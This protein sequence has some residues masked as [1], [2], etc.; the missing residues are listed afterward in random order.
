VLQSHR[1]GSA[2]D[3]VRGVIDALGSFTRQAEPHD[4]LTLLAAKRT[5]D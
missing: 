4:D 2:A 5:G 1:D 3:L